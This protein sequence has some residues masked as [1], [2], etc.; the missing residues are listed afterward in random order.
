VDRIFRTFL[1]NTAAD[2]AELQKRSDVVALDPLPP[3]PPSRYSCAFR[4]PYLRR[5]PSGIVEIVEGPV[6]CGISFPDDYLRSA[7]P[8]LYVKL[9]SVLN[10][11]F[12]HPNVL[13]G[14]VCLGSRFAPGTPIGELV[15]EL[16]E[17][18][19]YRNCTVDERNALNPE[20]C[21]L[22]REYPALLDRLERPPLFRSNRAIQTAVRPV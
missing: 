1:E 16:F 18:V 22:L 7:D 2:A 11:G 8:S 6:L 3:Q 20:A 15:W 9:A 21:R 17:I 10:S 14:S 12:L 13:L 4:V 5:Q 19:T